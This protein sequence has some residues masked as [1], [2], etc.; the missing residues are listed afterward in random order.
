MRI[1]KGYALLIM[2]LATLIGFPVLAW[3]VLSFLEIDFLDIFEIADN[4]IYL[5]PIYLG[6]GVSFGL[7]TIWLSETDYFR[8][9]LEPINDV[10]S[11]FKITYFNAFFVSFCAGVGEE[12]FFRGAMQKVVGIWITSVFFILIHVF[13]F[14]S[15]KNYRL[16]LYLILMVLFIAFLGWSTERYNLWVAIAAHFSYDLVLLFY[17]RYQKAL[18]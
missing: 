8:S 7:F 1:K 2:G 11:Q 13:T 16:N 5:V 17:Y 6:I 9:A 12:I 3:P 4:Q 15:L 10:L 14:I 18:D